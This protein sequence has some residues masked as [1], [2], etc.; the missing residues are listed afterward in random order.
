LL[1]RRNTPHILHI[2]FLVGPG[3]RRRHGD[4]SDVELDLEITLA[5]V[6]E[7]AY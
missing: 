6:E 3:H 7:I 1:R 5:E 2:S 4:E